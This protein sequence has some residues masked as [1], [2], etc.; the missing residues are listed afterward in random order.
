M[1]FQ[2][3]SNA[4]ASVPTID[5]DQLMKSDESEIKRLV[6]ASQMPGVFYLDL[7]GPSTKASLQFLP[8]IYKYAQQYFEQDEE[9]KKADTRPG[10]E[11]G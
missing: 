9:T 5:L 10:I 4:L 1:S 8:S 7:K 11:R 2:Q 3:V 6:E